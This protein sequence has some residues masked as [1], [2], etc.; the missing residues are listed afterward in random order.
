M[1]IGAGRTEAMVFAPGDYFY[2][3]QLYNIGGD[4]TLTDALSQMASLLTT[5]QPVAAG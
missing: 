4:D 2:I 1:V 5:R 3:V